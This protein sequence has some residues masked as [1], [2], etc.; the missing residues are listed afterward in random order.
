MYGVDKNEDFT[1]LHVLQ[2]KQ[3]DLPII[4]TK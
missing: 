3:I 2:E 4:V 1:I